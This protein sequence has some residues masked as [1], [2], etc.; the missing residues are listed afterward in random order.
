MLLHSSTTNQLL[1]ADGQLQKPHIHCLP[2]AAGNR[3]VSYLDALHTLHSIAL[4]YIH[5][6]GHAQAVR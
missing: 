4:R 6:H 5:A 2:T 1:S 3:R